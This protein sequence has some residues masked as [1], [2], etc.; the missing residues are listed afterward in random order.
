MKRLLSIEWSKIFYY[1]SAQVFT[2]LY[3]T[4][5]ILLGVVISFIK[6]NLNGLEFNLRELGYFNFPYIWQNLTYLFA[7]GKIF[8]GVILIMNITNEYTNGTLKQ[9]LIDGLSKN[10]FLSSK[11][12]TV[13]VLTLASTAF[14]FV[15]ALIL[16]LTLSSTEFG[17]YEGI[18]YLGAYFIK[19][20]FFFTFCTFLGVLLRKSVFALLGFFVWWIVEGIISVVEV[21]IKL[22]ITDTGKNPADITLISNYLPLGSSSSLIPLTKFD[23]AGILMNKSAFVY[24]PVDK[25]Y[26]F[27]CILYTIVFALLSKWILKKRDL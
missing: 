6:P 5:L 7:I 9:N 3:F 11:F 21:L 22:N 16:G 4:L 19:L 14:L 27:T 8:L 26:L 23:I 24:S 2:I 25:S 15:I 10:E 1:K 20:L 13:L 12:L 18:E 17:F